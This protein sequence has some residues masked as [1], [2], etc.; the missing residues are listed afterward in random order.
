VPATVIVGL[1]WG[2]EGKAKILDEFSEHADVVCRYQGGSN[3]GH[4]VVVDGE[5]Y[6][7]HLV[8]CGVA[9]PGKFCCIGNGVA[10]DPV[11]LLEEIRGF[12]ERG[13]EIRSRLLISERAHLVLPCHKRLEALAEKALGDSAI[14]TTLR[15]IGPC[16]ADKFSRSGLRVADIV[17][18]GFRERAERR[19]RDVNAVIERVH[20]E[21]PMT[22]DEAVAPAVQAVRE[23]A[24]MAG[25]VSAR[26]ND[27][28]DAGK[29][30]LL[31]GAQATLLD[32]DFGTYPYV[33]SSSSSALGA[34]AG[35]GVAPWRV[36]RVVGLVKAYTTRVGAGPF[37]TEDLGETG[38]RLRERGAEYGTTTGRPRRCG[39]LDAVSVRYAARLN[40][41]H[42]I[43]VSKLDVLSGEPVVRIAT[44]YRLPDGT[45]TASFPASLD[46]LQRAEPVYEE[47]EGWTEDIEEARA[48]D[49][50]PPAARRYV[51]R[52]E[53]L[54]GVKASF[55]SVGKDRGATIR[56]KS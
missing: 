50:L 12:E 56:W 41:V 26:L 36:S 45:E 14:G 4:T 35:A 30:V 10:L 29:N 11:A 19:L 32:V 23:L 5:T 33:T 55:V 25:D 51:A 3:A 6:K 43:A 17:R 47:L 2:D 22:F 9:R 38:A 49:D 34:P 53:E 39:W 31:E 8:P 16:Y 13:L 15:G 21:P 46:D 28:L 44:A 54:A 24:P 40:G 42:A 52:L 27:A 18:D 7:F 48:P 37:P 1:Q 20:G